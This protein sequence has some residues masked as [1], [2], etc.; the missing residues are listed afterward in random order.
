MES[1]G[2]Y[3]RTFESL[4]EKVKAGELQ[5]VDVLKYR[6]ALEMEDDPDT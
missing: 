1:A 3:R 2:I 4:S 5:G 6:S